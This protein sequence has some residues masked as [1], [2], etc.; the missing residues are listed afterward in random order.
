MTLAT[1]KGG[2]RAGDPAQERL[3]IGMG[4]DGNRLATS[5]AHM[6]DDVPTPRIRERQRIRSHVRRRK[7]FYLDLGGL[8]LYVTSTGWLHPPVIS[9]TGDISHILNPL[10]EL[11][12]PD[13]RKRR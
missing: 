6:R 11:K 4:A 3:P 2:S 1:K 9:R 8:E 13:G 5:V 12:E 10:P 7:P